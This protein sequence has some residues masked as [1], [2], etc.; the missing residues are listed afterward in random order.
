M[1]LF[2]AAGVESWLRAPDLLGVIH[3]FILLWKY[4]LII[5]QPM[6]TPSLPV[7]AFLLRPALRTW[8]CLTL[9]DNPSSLCAQ[10]AIWCA[11]LTD[12]GMEGQFANAVFQSIQCGKT[13]IKSS[14]PF[15]L[16]PCHI[17]CTTLS[18]ALWSWSHFI[19]KACM[20]RSH[21]GCKV[22]TGN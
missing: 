3:Y 4:G 9:M 13:F 6:S 12:R 14:V 16:S 21:G 18:G 1:W 15:F 10:H 17:I 20:G 2:C 7:S 5:L 22:W 19:P 11:I 8:S